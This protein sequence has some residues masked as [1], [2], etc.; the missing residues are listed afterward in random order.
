MCR[1]RRY[2][3][4]AVTIAMIA[5]VAGGTVSSP[6]TA[7][8]QIVTVIPD[9]QPVLVH[10]A[11]FHNSNMPLKIQI[12]GRAPMDRVPTGKRLVVEYATMLSGLPSGGSIS[13]ARIVTT[14]L[15]YGGHAVAGYAN[16]VPVRTGSSTT[17]SFFS[18]SHPVRFFAEPGVTLYA[19]VAPVDSGQEQLSAVRYTSGDT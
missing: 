5:L 8:T 6:I 2:M 17:N 19:I 16:L 12:P 18:A 14:L 11:A 15:G 13:M 9:G 4:I 1:L 3:V 10:G 7:Q